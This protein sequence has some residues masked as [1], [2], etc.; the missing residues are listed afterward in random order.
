MNREL[1][2]LYGDIGMAIAE[3]RA[4]AGWGDAVVEKPR[5]RPDTRVSRRSRGFFT[6]TKNLWRMQQFYLADSSR[7]FSQQAVREFRIKRGGEKLSQ[8]VR[9]LLAEPCHGGTVQRT[10][11]GLR[12]RPARLYSSHDREIRLG[13][14]DILLNQ[15]KAQAYE[16]AV[17]G[18]EERVTFMPEA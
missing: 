13:S 16:R 7:S 12:P 1:I 5:S 9:E 2:S 17:K 3:K 11:Q 10:R 4:A 18:K 15:I 8:A 14:R 6:R